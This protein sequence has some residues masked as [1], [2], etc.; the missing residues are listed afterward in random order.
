MAQT[1]TSL[2]PKPSLFVF[3]VVFGFWYCSLGG[4]KGQVRWPKVPPHLA[5]N[6][7][8]FSFCFSFLS[9]LLI[10]KTCFPLNKG[11]LDYFSVSP[12]VSPECFFLSLFYFLFLCLS[13]V[14]CFLPSFFAFFF[15]S[16]CFPGFVFLFLS[17]L[18]LLLFHA[19]NNIKTLNLK[20][21]WSSILSVFLVCYLRF[22]FKSL[23]L[24]LFLS[25]FLVLLFV[26]PQCFSFRECK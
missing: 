14:L 15:A 17:L 19:K 25:W 3:F 22:S 21:C 10:E 16:F 6:P 2:G 5:L 24:P 4:F 23:S 11:I 12:F 18:S 8:Y 1:A 13:L 20:V 26:Q 7:P 9:L